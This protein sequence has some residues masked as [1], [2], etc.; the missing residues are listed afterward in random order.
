MPDLFN[1]LFKQ[2]LIVGAGGF[3]GAIARFLVGTWIVGRWA[4]PSHAATFA[5]NVSGS[6]ALG[7]LATLIAQ[8]V[9]ASPQWRLAA[10]IGFLGAYTTFSTYEYESLR[11]GLTWAALANLA[12]S[13]AAGYGAVWLGVRLAHLFA[14]P[15][16]P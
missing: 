10:T 3:L 5:I 16:H 11:L 12:G 7:L 8:G 1:G 4:A 14:P 9:L 2:C 6:F 15:G 13:V